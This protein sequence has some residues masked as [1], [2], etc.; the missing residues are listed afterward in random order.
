VF[1]LIAV[2]AFAT[3]PRGALAQTAPQVEVTSVDNS[4]WPSV[5]VTLTVQ[6][7][8]GQPVPGL[9]QDAFSAQIAGEPV[10]ISSLGTTSDPGLGVAV[11]LTFDT[12]GSMAGPPLDQ[13]KAAGKSLL[14][15]LGTDDVAAIVAFSDSPQVVQ[16]FTADRAA[17]NSAVDALQSGGNTAL[18]AAV[19]QTA[20]LARQAPLPRRAVVLLS[21]GVDFGGIGGVDPA[22]TIASVAD[23]GALFFSVG[24]G[25]DLEEQYLQQL[26]DAGH[27]QLLL[28][29]TPGDLQALY[30]G[31]GN[32]LRQQYVLTLDAPADLPGG[33]TSLQ[34]QVTTAG[35]TA[36]ATSGLSVPAAV[37]AVPTAEPT[38]VPSATQPAQQPE[39]GGSSG[40]PWLIVV[41]VVAVAAVGAGT[42]LLVRRRRAAVVVPEDVVP[43]ERR[44]R[45][46][47]P[48]AFPQIVRA[49]GTE[50]PTAWIE[51]PDERKTPLTG[52][53]MTIGFSLDC[54]LQLPPDGDV[55][56]E[57]VRVWWR[58]GRYMLH[59]LSNAG[60]VMVAGR[61]ATWVVLEDGDEIVVGGCPLTFREP[62]AS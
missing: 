31:A 15:L 59:N 29:P 42:L 16:P 49:A 30:E 23:S 8:S 32:I 4:A 3:Q 22:S 37:T 9:S 26:A 38:A 52:S 10:A 56:V 5:Q 12:S 43:E 46:N 6:D 2:L 44:P 36:V 50:E 58:D 45:S 11:I 51:G 54:T 24:L 28:A 20:D 60:I 27:G 14:A 35:G 55:H 33:D 25:A 47:E 21:D 34:V 40:F 62:P 57:R 13:A 7:D 18:Y 61:P 41:G 17:L 53:P 39:P 48:V 19:A 1:I